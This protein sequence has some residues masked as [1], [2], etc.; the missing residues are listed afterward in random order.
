VPLILQLFLTAFTPP[1]RVVEI[2]AVAF[3]HVDTGSFEH[4]FSCGDISA[5]TTRKPHQRFHSTPA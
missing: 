1:D 4:L 5:V 2:H 3:Y